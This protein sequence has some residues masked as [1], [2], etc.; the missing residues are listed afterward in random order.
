[1]ILFCS[2]LSCSGSLYPA[3]AMAPLRRRRFLECD[4]LEAKRAEE[5]NVIKEYGQQPA[6]WQ[7]Q[8]GESSGIL[9]AQTSQE[10]FEHR[11]L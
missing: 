9:F 5:E 1:V 11:L 7:V 10:H 6:W 2:I 4:D 8:F 3:T